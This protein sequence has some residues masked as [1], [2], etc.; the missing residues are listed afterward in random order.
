MLSND[1]IN[2]TQDLN[3]LYVE[4]EKNLREDITSILSHFFKNVISAEDGEEAFELYVKDTSSK[5]DYFDIVFT[6]IY[7]PKINGIELIEKIYEK[8]KDQ[9]VVVVS[10]HNESDKLMDLIHLGITNF[11]QKPF[12]RQAFQKVFL[13]VTQDIA[14]KKEKV[15]FLLDKQ[16]YEHK[17]VLLEDKEKSLKELIDNIS[18]HWRQP[19]SLISTIASGILLDHEI[20]KVDIEKNDKHL[21]KIIETTMNMSDTIDTFSHSMEPDEYKRFFDIKDTFENVKFLMHSKFMNKNITL[22]ESVQ[23][24]EIEQVE[25]HIQ[26][27]LI[28][29]FNNAID[30]M[31]KNPVKLLFVN[32]FQKDNNLHIVVKDN[33]TGIVPNTEDKLCEPYFTT[34]HKYHGTGLGLFVVKN[35]VTNDMN[36]SLDIQN[37]QYEYEKK[38]YGGVIVKIVIPL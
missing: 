1:L 22:I 10:A 15:Q 12:S 9:V 3:I 28:N 13:K 33:G 26:Q 38:E 34:K 20:N 21:Q 6:D 31:V 11:I 24:I 16:L 4:D 29:I 36:G 2:Y 32:I 17:K 35:F 19:L 8:N 18:H 7:M 23:K 14:Y 27:I 25:Q 5:K 30:A 37:I